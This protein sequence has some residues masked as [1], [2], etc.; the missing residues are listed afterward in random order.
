MSKSIKQYKDAMDKIKAS[1]NFMSRT[2]DLL[3]G[4]V[5][6]ETEIAIRQPKARMARN[7]TLTAGVGLA[8][9]IIAV[10][11]VR[12]GMIQDTADITADAGSAEVTSVTE[13]TE[14]GTEPVFIDIQDDSQMEALEQDMP[15]TR[16][17][18][19]AEVEEQDSAATTA[20]EQPAE[21]APSIGLAIAPQVTT[22]PAK[23]ETVPT[24]ETSA[25]TT[26]KPAPKPQA[27]AVYDVEEAEYDDD[28][29]VDEEAVYD[30]ADSEPADADY[31]DPIIGSLYT[32]DYSL[33]TVDIQS[34]TKDGETE[35]LHLSAD[36]A[37]NMISNIAS[38]LSNSVPF[39]PGS[40]FV[41]EFVINISSLSDG[42][43]I[44]TI[45]LTDNQFA[46]ITR[47]FSDR[48]ERTTYLIKR[49]DYEAL[50]KMMYLHFGSESDF[51]AFLALKSGK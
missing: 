49:G 11:A 48:Q 23:T 15:E 38:T 40:S 7:I 29:A 28:A 46:V 45:Y 39:N 2:E 17:D 9:C 18:D 6:N 10:L 47:H 41:S 26:A 22:K 51:E 50:E 31:S 13:V 24:A 14:T 35:N 32:L 5:K 1:E 43:D 34:C 25:E 44:F 20:D 12:S 4:A 27:D 16:P 3:K 8:A 33:C 30:S 19:S 42:S 37:Q 36:E 21:E